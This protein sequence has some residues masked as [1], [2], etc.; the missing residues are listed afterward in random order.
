M[1]CYRC[2]K[3]GGCSIFQKLY[4]TSKDFCINDCKDYYEAPEYKYRKI[5]EHDDL[6]RAIYDYFTHQIDNKA[7]SREYSDEEIKEFI[8][9]AMWAL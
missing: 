6:M 8:T 3:I 4:S 5:A 7:L 9:R 2:E 1:I